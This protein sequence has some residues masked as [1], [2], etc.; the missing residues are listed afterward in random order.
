MG[1]DNHIHVL[2]QAYSLQM[3]SLQCRSS[4]GVGRKGSTASGDVSGLKRLPE[5]SSRKLSSV[6]ELIAIHEW[7]VFGTECKPKLNAW[8]PDLVMPARDEVLQLSVP[9][10]VLTRFDT[11]L[12]NSR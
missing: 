6:Q 5:V 3:R 10:L 11:G 1:K 8:S 9:R 2:D 4:S 7:A 12:A